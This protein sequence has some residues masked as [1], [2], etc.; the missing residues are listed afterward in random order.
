MLRTTLRMAG[1][2]LA[3]LAVCSCG[4]LK[5]TAIK[6]VADTLSESGTTIRITTGCRRG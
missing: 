3:V 4:A 5:S 2:G 6:T 1:L